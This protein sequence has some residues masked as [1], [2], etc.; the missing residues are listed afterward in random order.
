MTDF[1]KKNCVYALAIDSGFLRLL[2]LG[3]MAIDCV[4]KHVG[5]LCSFAARGV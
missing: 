2:L 3:F 1:L 4:L 5:C